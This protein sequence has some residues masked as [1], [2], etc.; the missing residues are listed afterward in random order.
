MVRKNKSD[1][2]PVQLPKDLVDEVERIIKIDEIKKQGI[3][4]ISQFI[5]RT[6]NEEFE[7]LKQK[8]ISHV[9]MYEDHVKIMDRKLGKLGRI[10]SVYFKKGKTSW[11]DY[12]EEPDCIHVQYA[13]E[14]PEVRKILEKHGLKPPPSRVD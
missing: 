5:S 6:V 2:R 9:N 13:W 4:S 7:K 14:I 1:W 3:T 11:C 12:C 8:N 10:I